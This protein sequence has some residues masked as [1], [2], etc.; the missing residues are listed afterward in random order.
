MPK[1]TVVAEVTVVR[2]YQTIVVRDARSPEDALEGAAWE[3]L[4]LS[5]EQFEHL[6]RTDNQ[7][8]LLES[9][10]QDNVVRDAEEEPE[11][12]G[13]EEDGEDTGI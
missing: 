5:F 10:V 13:D 8:H 6:R 3:A 2:K 1:Y 4:G 7:T 9:F 11:D 12:E